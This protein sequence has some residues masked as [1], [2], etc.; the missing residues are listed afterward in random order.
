MENSQ[1]YLSIF[2]P[3]NPV[4]IFLQTAGNEFSPIICKN[5]SLLYLQHASTGKGRPSG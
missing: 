5:R 3:G 4:F 2:N 1:H